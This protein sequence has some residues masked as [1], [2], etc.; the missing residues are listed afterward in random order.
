MRPEEVRGRV[1]LADLALCL[2]AL[3]VLAGCA[4]TERSS[5]L[6]VPGPSA[7]FGELIDERGALTYV[8]RT[9]SAPGDLDR[10]SEVTGLIVMRRA[11]DMRA[12]G[13]HYYDDGFGNLVRFGVFKAPPLGGKARY[14]LTFM[15]GGAMQLAL[16]FRADA[17]VD[18]LLQSGPGSRLGTLADPDMQWFLD[19]MSEQLSGSANVAEAANRCLN[20]AGGGGVGGLTADAARDINRLKEPD[21]ERRSGVPGSV[22]QP[23]RSHHSATAVELEGGYTVKATSWEDADGTS[24]YR[25]EMHDGEGNLVYRETGTKNARG[26]MV[27]QE[28][29]TVDHDSATGGSI[30]RTRRYENGRKTEDSEVEIGS[31]VME[32]DSGGDEPAPASGSTTTRPG[33]ECGDDCPVED[34]RCAPAPNDIASLW[35]CAVQT[36]FSLLEC[37][38]RARDA[39][40]TATG[41]RC[42]TERGPEDR[43]TVQCSERR[44]QECL[45]G[46]ESIVA[47]LRENPQ[48]GGGDDAPDP[49]DDFLRDR[50]GTSRGR[51]GLYID[52]TPMGAVFAGFCREG[53]EQFCRPGGGRF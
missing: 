25:I 43:P 53:G 32:E 21:C 34:P 3:I 37:I 5:R 18:V 15:P 27:E 40:Y 31:A 28:I 47:C 8:S 24:G 30:T 22:M 7:V 42:R 19:C 51:V 13:G 23:G 14:A 39:I 50:F 1:D 48:Y 44:L 38:E 10:S 12:I 35:D 4:T 52:T 6:R 46:G 16:D 9:Y 17:I 2:C 49:N 33:P 26:Q 29:E 36:D 20:E 11:A 41:G 45:E